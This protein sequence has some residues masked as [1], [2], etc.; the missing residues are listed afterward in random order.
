[1]YVRSAYEAMLKGTPRPI[2]AER[3]YIWQLSS[4]LAT[5]NWANM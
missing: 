3:W 1:M 4:P 5:K 2:S